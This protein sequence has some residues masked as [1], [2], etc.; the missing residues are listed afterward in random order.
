MGR[1]EEDAQEQVESGLEW[2]C[3]EVNPPQGPAEQD[4]NDQSRAAAAAIGTEA[5]EGL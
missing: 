5:A 3:F 4:G 2:M 1:A